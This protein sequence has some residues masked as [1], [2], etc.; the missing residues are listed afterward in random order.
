[1]CTDGP[2]SSGQ[3]GYTD[4]GGQFKLTFAN[5]DVRFVCPKCGN[6]YANKNGLKAHMDEMHNKIGVYTDTGVK[7]VKESSRGVDVTNTMLRLM[8]ASGD[9]LARYVKPTSPTG[10]L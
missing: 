4:T 10:V 7:L 6:S 2:G 5:E 1:M 8:L 9:T 3:T